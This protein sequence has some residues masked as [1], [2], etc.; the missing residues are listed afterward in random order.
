MIENWLKRFEEQNV[1]FVVLDQSQDE[2][3]IKSLRRQPG[4]SVDFEGD[5]AVIFVRSARD[6]KIEETHAYTRLG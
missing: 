1:Q 6:S 5:G 4:W 3:F 2:E